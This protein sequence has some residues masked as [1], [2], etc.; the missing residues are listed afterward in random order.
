[1][2]RQSQSRRIGKQEDPDGT[3]YEGRRRKVLRARAGIKFMWQ[4]QE[5]N[6]R[7][8]RTTRSRRGRMLSGFDVERGGRGHS[9]ARILSVI[10]IST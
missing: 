6:L 1:M 5:R 9:I 7:N 10:S 2:L 8:W 4:G 3:K